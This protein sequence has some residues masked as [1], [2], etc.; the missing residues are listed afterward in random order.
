MPL[1]NPGDIKGLGG[2]FVVGPG[3]SCT[4][5]HRMRT[6]RDHAELSDI[7]KAIGITLPLG[8]AQST[9]TNT[10][11]DKQGSVIAQR[12][13]RKQSRTPMVKEGRVINHIFEEP[14]LSER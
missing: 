12:S 6:S 2:E 13:V 10:E 14:T 3:L 5:A 1:K 8:L 4:Y 11:V 9:L 7:L